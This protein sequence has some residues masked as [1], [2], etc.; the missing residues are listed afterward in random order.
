[1]VMFSEHELIMLKVTGI[2]GWQASMLILQAPHSLEQHNDV[3]DSVKQAEYKSLCKDAELFYF[4][5]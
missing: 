4:I 2:H 3:L 1:M 5:F